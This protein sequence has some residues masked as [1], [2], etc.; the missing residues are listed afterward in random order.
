MDL[1]Y[2]LVTVVGA[3]VGAEVVAVI[4]A[5]LVTVVMAVV[6]AQTVLSKE[7]FCHWHFKYG[8][9][10]LLAFTGH[11]GYARAPAQTITRRRRRKQW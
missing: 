11:I 10:P 5:V 1:T 7:K 3:V 6:G 9:Q 4:V 2:S 8:F